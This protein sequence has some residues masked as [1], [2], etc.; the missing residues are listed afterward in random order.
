MTMYIVGESLLGSYEGKN[1]QIVYDENYT[2]LWSWKF[3]HVS[4][5][6]WL[7]SGQHRVNISPHPVVQFVIK[8]LLR[9][10]CL[11]DCYSLTDALIYFKNDFSFETGS[12]YL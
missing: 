11:H 2:I 10:N 4:Y 7:K 9:Q 3:Q 6:Y 12:L 5:S 1:I 8:L